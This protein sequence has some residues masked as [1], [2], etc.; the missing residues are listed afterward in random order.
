MLRLA[1][2]SMLFLGGFQLNYN[3]TFLAMICYYSIISLSDTLRVL[4]SISDS[5]S[6]EDLAKISKRGPMY[7]EIDCQLSSTRR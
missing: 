4:V 7:V 3:L 2:Q 6:L 1:A 5:D